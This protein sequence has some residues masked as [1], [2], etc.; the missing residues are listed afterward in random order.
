MCCV[1][2]IYN[3]QRPVSDVCI[4]AHETESKDACYIAQMVY[5]YPVA[6]TMSLLT[7]YSTSN[8]FDR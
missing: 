6:V 7:Y 2:L 8:V 5:L 1:L 4:D 3:Q